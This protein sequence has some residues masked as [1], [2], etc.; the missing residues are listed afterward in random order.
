MSN[1]IEFLDRI[2]RNPMPTADAYAASVAA[3]DAGAAEREALLA[4]DAGALNDLLGG[5]PVMR[6]AVFEPSRQPDQEPD[7]DVP[8]GDEEEQADE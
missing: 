7:G 2:G 5:R 1:V 6:C 8:D 4:R 3:L